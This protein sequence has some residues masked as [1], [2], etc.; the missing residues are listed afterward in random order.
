MVECGESAGSAREGVYLCRVLSVMCVRNSDGD[1]TQGY[2]PGG[3]AG[4]FIQFQ[5]SQLKKRVR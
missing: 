4:G 2:A 3:A 1:R 5:G